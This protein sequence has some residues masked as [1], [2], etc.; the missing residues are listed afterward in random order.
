M[1]HSGQLVTT[2]ARIAT[3]WAVPYASAIALMACMRAMR[4]AL[5]DLAHAPQFVETGRGYR[6]LTAVTVETCP[7]AP[8][9]RDMLTRLAVR[10]APAVWSLQVLPVLSMRV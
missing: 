7:G 5:D 10:C 1:V 8:E 6:F 9:E 3:V 2:D 4:Q